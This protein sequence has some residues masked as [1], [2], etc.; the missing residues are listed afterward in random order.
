MFS[1]LAVLR[2][3]WSLLIYDLLL[4]NLFLLITLF[5][6]FRIGDISLVGKR[7]AMIVLGLNSLIRT[8]AV[9]P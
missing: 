5:T 8:L 2:V 7:G 4:L 1:L 3:L 9:R 6:S